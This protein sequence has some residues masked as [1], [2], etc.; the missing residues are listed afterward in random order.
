[1]RCIGSHLENYD[2]EVFMI[3]LF[4]CQ[5]GDFSTSLILG[6]TKILVPRPGLPTSLQRVVM[7]YLV[8]RV[9]RASRRQHHVETMRHA[10]PV[11]S[12]EYSTQSQRLS[13]MNH[14]N[15]LGT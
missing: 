9:P 15:I 13:N 10:A 2:L 1:M 3:V 6:L 8:M 7:V 5:G 4:P 11:K 14:A 12:M